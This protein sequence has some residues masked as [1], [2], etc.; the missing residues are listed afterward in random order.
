MSNLIRSRKSRLAAILATAAV[1]V[2]VVA[3]P[4]AAQPVVTGAGLVNVTLVDVVDVN[5]NNVIA[6]VPI[7]VA[8]NICDVSANVIAKQRDAA[9][10]CDA[11]NDQLPV[12][13][14]R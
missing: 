2:G 8:A 12:A 11:S 5:G 6:Q 4:A 1:S 3:G 14:Q 13:F 9:S 7:G 10:Q